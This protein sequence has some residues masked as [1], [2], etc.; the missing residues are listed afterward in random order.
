MITAP[1]ED[2]R[3]VKHLDEIARDGL[4]I[5]LL[6]DGGL[7]GAVVHGTRMV[8]QMR[9]N[10]R[11]GILETL[12]VGHGYIAAALMSAQIK[13]NDKIR[14]LLDC[15]G[16]A[17]GLSVEARATGQI[18]GYLHA[19]PIPVEEPPESFDMAPFIGGGTISVTKELEVAKHPFTGQ[20]A[21]EE[22]TIARDLARYYLHSEQTPAAFSLSVKF[23]EDG[24]VI[25]AG[26]IF[27]Q[28]MPGAEEETL[29]EAE[30]TLR[31]MPS[32]GESF[33]RGATG[34]SLVK[35]AFAEFDPDHLGSRGAEFYCGCSKE[36]F[37]LFI[38]RVSMDELTSIREE[39]PF[40]LK[41]T[42]HN[43]G[44]TYEF[45]PEEIEE[46]Y[47]ERLARQQG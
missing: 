30:E 23:D 43:C 31:G 47:Q 11:L 44:S 41:T 25:G 19:V 29:S 42:C 15:D 21:L 13:G 46:I 18:R 8:N 17:E 6:A 4:D 32:L 2:Q 38:G 16:P 33:A 3:V 22:G 7:R 34:V 28:A 10:H 14:L 45:T 37:G 36:R 20:I 35:E 40:P 1:I 12:I 24:R 27:L 39:G 5:F 26:G 9:R